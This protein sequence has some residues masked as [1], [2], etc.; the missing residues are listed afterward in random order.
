MRL[1]IAGTMAYQVLTAS[2]G[3]S[4]PRRSVVRFIRL[5]V[6]TMK[7]KTFQADFQN[8]LNQKLSIFKMIS[9]RKMN[10][11]VYSNTLK[12]SSNLFWL[13]HRTDSDVP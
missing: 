10:V 3:T 11:N 7:S 12:I 1:A 13:R 4:T 8:S 6:T 5:D 2:P 9:I